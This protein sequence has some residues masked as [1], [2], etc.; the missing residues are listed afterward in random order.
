MVDFH[1]P[2]PPF[3]NSNGFRCPELYPAKFILGPIQ[4]VG[5]QS[6]ADFL[7][8]EEDF[9]ET[10][11]D[12]EEIDII[13]SNV[14]CT[15]AV[16]IRI[17]NKIRQHYNKLNAVVVEKEKDSTHNTHFNHGKIDLKSLENFQKNR[18]LEEEAEDIDETDLDPDEI[19]TVMHQADCTRAQAVKALKKHRN[20]VDAIIDLT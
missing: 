16:A 19:D 5:Q 15:R 7:S 3:V 17:V 18:T 9:D 6:R 2:Q 4:F 11:L 8:L 20:M 14:V 13:T 10:D 12:F 1:P